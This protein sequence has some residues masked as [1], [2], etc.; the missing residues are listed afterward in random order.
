M[1]EPSIP[2]FSQLY[3]DYGCV[4]SLLLT[5]QCY[6]NEFS[7]DCIPA[8]AQYYQCNKH[9]IAVYDENFKILKVAPMQSYFL[10]S[11]ETGKKM[12]RFYLMHVYDNNL[13]GRIQESKMTPLVTE[14]TTA[15]PRYH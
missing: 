1:T 15:I 6:D 8:H 12:E 11:Y 9:G 7:V 13:L 14:N 10:H 4:A 2:V 5:F 3:Y